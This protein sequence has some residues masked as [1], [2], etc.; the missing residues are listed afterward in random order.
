MNIAVVIALGSLSYLRQTYR[1]RLSA[2]V[3]FV[4]YPCEQYL[5]GSR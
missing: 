4:Y 3:S 1:V 5:E 2:E